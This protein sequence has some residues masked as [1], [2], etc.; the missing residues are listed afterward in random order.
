MTALS[1]ETGRALVM[2]IGRFNRLLELNTPNTFGL[3]ELR[4]RF[5]HVSV[6]RIKDLARKSGYRGSTGKTMAVGQDVLLNMIDVLNGILPA[7]SQNH[8][9][10]GVLG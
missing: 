7:V 5:P 2:A 3:D 8:D 1:E 10:E 9:R 6:A 4:E